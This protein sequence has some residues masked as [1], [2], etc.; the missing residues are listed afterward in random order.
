[1]RYAVTVGGLVACASEAGAIPLPEGAR[2][3]RGRLAP[4]QLLVVDPAGFGL[5]ED[6]DVKRR[7]AGRFAYERW[8]R[9]T[10]RPL[11]PGDPV[12]PPSEPLTARQA[13]AG[14]TREEL[15]LLLR[16]AATSAHEPTSS[17]GDDTALPPLAGRARPLFSY[18]RQRFAQVTN[19]PIDHLRER[20]VTSLR[21]LLGARQ[22]LLALGQPQ[23]RC[24]S[25]RASSF[26]RRPS[27]PS[28]PCISKRRSRLSLRGAC[29]R[30]GAEAVAARR[31]DM[32][33]LDDRGDGA[34]IPSLLALGAVQSALVDAGLRT[35]TLADRP[36]RRTAR[37]RITSRACSATGPTRSARG[38][39]WR[40]S[41]RWLQPTSSAATGRS[42][43]EAQ[44]RFRSAIEDGVLKA[45]ARMGISDV[46]SYRGAQLFDAL[47]LAS[48][49]IDLCF[50]GTSSP[51]GGAG[52]A[53][54]ECDV[55]ARAPLP[56]SSRT[57]AT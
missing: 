19:P 53:E 37:E 46:A 31:C 27:M 51:L 2:V 4:G 8:L 43:R 10:R 1:M 21:T 36:E 6:A 23:E 49:V 56:S 34:A 50:P 26:F 16:A 32:L 45:M 9:R 55:A 13:R 14:I 42:P 25:S 12:E 3:R 40:R 44:L 48:E 35:R 29:E 38:S 17:M 7:L 54:L 22:P 20:E 28:T 18:F 30:L 39:R 33:V 11:D 52:F 47:G 15:S 57:P 41:P 24:S 5:E